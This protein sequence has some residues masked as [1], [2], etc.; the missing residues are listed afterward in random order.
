MDVF[1]LTGR[2]G[3]IEDFIG[4]VD[5]D[6][7]SLPT[8]FAAQILDVFACGE[9]IEF[10]DRGTIPFYSM[11]LENSIDTNNLGNISE[12]IKEDYEITSDDL[13]P[14]FDKMNASNSV[15]VN[16]TLKESQNDFFEFFQYG[17]DEIVIRQTSQSSF[18]ISYNDYTIKKNFT[19]PVRKSMIIEI[20]ELEKVLSEYEALIPKKNTSTIENER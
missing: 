1:K 14:I 16:L 12:D 6:N 13:Q 9:N 7:I 20:S 8:D 4:H 18:V 17:S 5:G 15:Q 3:D 10:K 11:F 2:L 19:V